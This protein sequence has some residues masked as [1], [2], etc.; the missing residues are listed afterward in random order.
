M[1]GGNNDVVWNNLIC[2]LLILS[3]ESINHSQYF[4][5]FRLSGQFVTYP[6][7]VARRRMQMAV[8]GAD[9]NL[10]TLRYSRK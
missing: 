4:H 2:I 7:D 3:I 9:G 1:I 5:V 10:A 8:R 6:L